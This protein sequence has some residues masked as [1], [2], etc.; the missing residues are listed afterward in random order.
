MALVPGDPAAEL[1]LSE[2]HDVGRRNGIGG[3]LGEA[4]AAQPLGPEKL[5]RGTL[6]RLEQASPACLFG[7]RTPA[8][9]NAY[10]RI[11][12]PDRTQPHRGDEY[13][14]PL[15]SQLTNGAVKMVS[16]DGF[17][18]A[19]NFKTHTNSLRSG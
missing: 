15:F 3:K 9:R 16:D 6:R 4:R 8:A 14:T 11:F 18:W 2:Q 10:G 19:A 12:W 7:A 5:R 1:L 13:R 17:V